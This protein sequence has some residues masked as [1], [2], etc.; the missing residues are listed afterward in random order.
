MR[1][2]T[3]DRKFKF[4]D[5]R[6]EAWRPTEGEVYLHD[7]ERPNLLLR[8]SPK[9]AK[10]FYFCRTDRSGKTAKQRVGPL[11]EWTVEQARARVDVLNGQTVEA[12]GAVPKRDRPSTHTL[13]DAFA[14][15][16]TFREGEGGR[17]VYQQRRM[18]ALYLERFAHVLMDEIDEVWVERN[19]KHAVARGD[20]LDERRK[21]LRRSGG[22]YTANNVLVLFRAV[23]ARYLKVNKLKGK[24]ANPC[25]DV[26][27]YPT[28][29][30]EECMSP[31]E[32]KRFL[33]AIDTFKR[34]HCVFKHTRPGRGM[35]KGQ[36]IESRIAL[37]DVLF[38]CVTLGQRRGAVA[39]M[40]WTD[41]R[42]NGDD[43]TWRIPPIKGNKS[44]KWKTIHL[45]PKAV[46]LL[47][48][49]RQRSGD[50]EYVFPGARGT[51]KVKDPRK[52]YHKILVIAGIDNPHLTIHDLRAAFVTLGVV[53]GKTTEAI[54][55]AVG[56]D[57][58][59]TTTEHYVRLSK[60]QKRSVTHEI[61]A[62]MFEEEAA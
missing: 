50:G 25:V 33:A 12:G 26:P 5:T 32:I 23:Y 20:G 51:A 47:R 38:C 36:P 11:G 1:T 2:V 18:Y 15:Y 19:I 43:P 35:F 4:T 52:V 24:R 7:T 48:E 56:H 17:S 28:S 42:L 45:P 60:A 58:P 27:L 14:D 8:I 46:E 59:D 22:T 44:R 41:L 62:A 61:S 40:R 29:R 9:G 30:R 49:R 53:K 37:A 10:T 34:E 31:E 16:I 39:G 6:L 21:A 55:A 57:S 3:D 54:A 13:G